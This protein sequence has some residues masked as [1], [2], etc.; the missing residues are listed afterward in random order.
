VKHLVGL[1]SGT[2]TAQN[3]SESGAV[4]TVRLPLASTADVRAGTGAATTH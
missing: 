4:F 3:G 2:V 1:L